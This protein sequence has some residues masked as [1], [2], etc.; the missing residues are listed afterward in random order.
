[1]LCSEPHSQ[2][3]P[4]A[5]ADEDLEE[6]KGR[7]RWG[8]IQDGHGAWQGLHAAAHCWPSGSQLILLARR[9]QGLT[10]RP[11]EAGGQG[12]GTL[13]YHQTD[14]PLGLS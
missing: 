4:T 5:E 11:V 9:S 2:P 12:P 3:L 8:R 14:K 1:M 7:G 13:F 10:C 6:G